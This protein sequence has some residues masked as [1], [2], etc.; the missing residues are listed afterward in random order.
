MTLAHTDDLGLVRVHAGP[1]TVSHAVPMAA[2]SCI[3]CQ[4]ENILFSPLVPSVPL[5]LPTLA[6]LPVFSA[7]TRTQ[8]SNPFD[9]TSPRAPPHVS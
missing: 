6:P 7:R 2:D 1:A 9:H 5:P 3:A 8:I 4:W